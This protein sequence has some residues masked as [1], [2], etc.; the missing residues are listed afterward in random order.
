MQGLDDGLYRWELTWPHPE[1]DQTYWLTKAWNKDTDSGRRVK[2]DILNAMHGYAIMRRTLQPGFTTVIN[3]GYA[4]RLIK[5]MI[6]DST[7][8]AELLQA[9]LAAGGI[10]G[11]L[12]GLAIDP[13]EPE[14]ILRQDLEDLSHVARLMLG[15]RLGELRG[16]PSG[17]KTGSSPFKVMSDLKTAKEKSEGEPSTPIGVTRNPGLGRQRT[18]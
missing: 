1:G 14:K 10:V 16:G 5:E 13:D 9:N 2:P 17:R 8:E 3:H 4:E 11:W 7:D 18:E 15:E 6:K 12:H